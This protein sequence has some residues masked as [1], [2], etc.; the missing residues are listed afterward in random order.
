M[1]NLFKSHYNY[2]RKIARQH[3][4]DA[5][6]DWAED[7]VQDTFVKAYKNIEKYSSDKGKLQTWLTTITINLCRDFNRKKVN[8]ERK[9]DD[10][11][12]FQ[13]LVDSTE[14]E[15]I[16]DF[17]NYTDVLSSKELKVIEM[18]YFLKMS[19]K[20]M[21]P[22]LGVKANSVPMISKRA[23]EKLR[24]NFLSRGMNLDSFY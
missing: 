20:E 23:L 1:E 4:F 19:A 10:L 18:R 14:S 6:T 21:E 5:N 3:L 2:L 13:H 17:S 15:M 22:L 9:Y 16:F 12:S 7:I 24:M 11:N 8:L